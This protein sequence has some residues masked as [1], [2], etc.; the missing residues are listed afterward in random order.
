LPIA[1]I[2]D[3]APLLE[4]NT[5]TTQAVFTVSLS[6]AYSQPVTI[7]YTT[8]DGSAKV[9]GGDYQAKSGTLTFAP[10]QT[11]QT[12]TVLVNGDRL[13]ESSETFSINLTNPTN[14]F[15]A[16]A[17]GAGTI[18]DDE[19]TA[20][21]IASLSGLEGNTG[22]T[23]MTFTVTL[24]APCDVPLNIE[25]A[26]SD[27]TDEWVY[28]GY[29]SAT[30]DGDYQSKSGTLTFA[31]GETSKP[32]TVLVNGDRI[33]G[34]YAEYFLVNLNNSAGALLGRSQALG[35]IQDDEPY[36]S[37]E[38]AS[39]AEG[40][41]GTTPLI[42]TVRL[43]A[44]YDAPVTVNYAT[45]DGNASA[46]IDY[47][48][49]AGT[50]TFVPG[51]TSKTV[52][53]QVT[54]DTVYEG[55]EYFQ[56]NL[57]DADAATIGNGTGYGA[58]VDDDPDTPQI[59][60]SD[61]TTKEGNAGK[62]AFVFTVDLS[63]ASSSRVTV[64]YA[65]A[66]GSA[67]ANGDFQATTGA[68]TFAPGQTSKTVT[69]QVKGDTTAE[70][71]EYFLLNLSGA[72]GATIVDSEA[73]GTIIDDDVP[74]IR[75]SN[76]SKKE[77]DSGTTSFVFTVSLS[78]ASSS[79]VTVNY[80]TADGTAKVGD[81]DYD[82]KSG[83]LTFATGETSKSITILVYGDKRKEARETFFV[84]LGNAKGA[85]IDDG[86]GVG[87]ITNDDN[88]RRADQH[89]VLSWAAINDALDDFLWSRR[90]KHGR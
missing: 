67:T 73:I 18:Q 45:F 49:T 4:G 86:Q 69:V 29:P 31:P 83:K 34:E 15:L 75:I 3:S 55:D 79:P 84:N 11:S 68:V 8:A 38:Q 42:F 58:I 5:G 53:V 65:T 39:V 22:T 50:L 74:K 28:Y 61:V 70:S 35:E 7:S 36:F 2:S 66:N 88:A 13:A 19:P 12:I 47:T 6:S 25:Y 63:A 9:A 62:T 14:A 40:N 26:T 85:I 16:D 43:S 48:P 56:L 1:T 21:I 76:V 78:A 44:S 80:A 57:V 59:S 71:D 23:P 51:E 37:I 54:G 33:A 60:I 20:S 41:A 82:T 52:A 30:V 10:G 89:Y 32:I 24:S 77:G 46:G 87:T 81:N 72:K 27:L 64:N 90:T 17:V